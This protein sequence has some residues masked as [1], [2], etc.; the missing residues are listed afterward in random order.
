MRSVLIIT[1]YKS[2][3]MIRNWF[4]FSQIRE[5]IQPEIYHFHEPLSWLKIE[6]A[7]WPGAQMSDRSP[8][9][10]HCT[11]SPRQ[12]DTPAHP[13][14]LWSEDILRT[15]S[16]VSPTCVHAAVSSTRTDAGWSR[17]CPL[18]PPPPRGTPSPSA[19]CTPAP[20]CWRRTCHSQWSSPVRK[21][22]WAYLVED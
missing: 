8:G 4:I 21:S 3:L 10:H 14:S 19:W 20:C 17:Q 7:D 22:V 15:S 5:R 12:S 13:P 11:S 16:W 9:G 18:S 1:P 2:M 6:N